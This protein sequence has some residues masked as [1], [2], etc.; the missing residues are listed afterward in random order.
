MSNSEFSKKILD[1]GT[2]IEWITNSIGPN[3]ERVLRTLKTLDEV[4]A[5]GVANDI[6]VIPPSALNTQVAGS[7]YKHRKIQP[8]E[9]CEANRLGA[10][11]S[12]IVKYITRWKQ[13]GGMNDLEKIKHCVDLLIETEQ[14][15]HRWNPRDNTWNAEGE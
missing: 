9:Y 14:K 8:I 1:D 7:H 12:A 15:Y 6:V 13:K 4:Y 11:E 2:R 10:C 3:T 5:T